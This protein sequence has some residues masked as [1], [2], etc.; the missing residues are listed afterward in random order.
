MIEP[1]S[2]QLEKC[3]QILKTKLPI[4]PVQKRNYLICFC[5]TRSGGGTLSKITIDPQIYNMIMPPR[6]KVCVKTGL[7]KK[8]LKIPNG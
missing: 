2:F 7:L 1:G 5:L 3:C 6:I 8:G 4:V